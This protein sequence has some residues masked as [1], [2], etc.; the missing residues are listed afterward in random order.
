MSSQADPR[1]STRA[2]NRRLILLLI[3]AYAAVVLLIAALLVVFAV[4]F[5]NRIS[6]SDLH[7]QSPIT[8]ILETYYKVNGGWDRVE[9]LVDMSPSSASE[10]NQLDWTKVVMLDRDGRI[11][12]DHGSATTGRIGSIY[13]DLPGD[14]HVELT[15]NGQ[16]IGSLVVNDLRTPLPW[17]FM[18]AVFRP[19]V[20]TSILLA[21]LT[22]VIGLLLMRRVAAPLADVIAAAQAVT[23]GNLTARVKVHGPDDLKALSDSFNRMASSLEHNDH[24]RRNMLADIAHELRTPLTVIRGRLEGIADGI[25][26]LDDAHLVPLLNETYLLERLIED[27]RVLALAEARQLHFDYHP[28]N[29]EELAQHVAS[30]FEAEAGE[31]G[32]RIDIQAEPSLPHVMGDPQRL[33]QVIG[34]LVSN[35]LRYAPESSKVCILVRAVEDGVE[36]AVS[37][38]G[39]GVSEEDLPHVFDRFWRG[40]K[41]RTRTSG[42]AGLG[43]AIALQLIEAQEG[44]IGA[45]NLLGGGLQVGFVLPSQTE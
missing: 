22:L 23:A 28:V 2:I 4:I 14:Q 31:A 24:E 30:L 1:S 38:E 39:P 43:L 45:K 6:S 32:I 44:K 13:Q 18:L 34:N 15:Q 26:P 19:L 29:L 8:F 37:D 20:L 35:A 9:S 3:R 33:E 27:L 40:E 11:L 16:T 36:L 12:V 7:Y 5:I 42:G 41:S 25:Y 10:D 21:I 17:E